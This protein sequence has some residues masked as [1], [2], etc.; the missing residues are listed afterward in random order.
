M[1]PH[2]AKVRGHAPQ[3]QPVELADGTQATG[4]VI[5]TRERMYKFDPKRQHAGSVGGAGQFCSYHPSLPNA[6]ALA[7]IIKRINS[8]VGRLES[9]L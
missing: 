4:E 1:E 2:P 7:S 8:E 9:A 5:D 3:H 6:V